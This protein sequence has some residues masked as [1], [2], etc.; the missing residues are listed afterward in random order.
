MLPL[1]CLTA[2]H[3]LHLRVVEHGEQLPLLCCAGGCL[4]AAAEM[5]EEPDLAPDAALVRFL[6]PVRFSSVQQPSE[7][8][9][10][11]SEAESKAK[12]LECGHRYSEGEGLAGRYTPCILKAE[13]S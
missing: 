13:S 5:F 1:C 8:R 2:L 9:S 12:Q 7:G 10:A 3:L 11:T 6:S 4:L